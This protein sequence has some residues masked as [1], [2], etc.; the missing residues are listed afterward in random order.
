MTLSSLGQTERRANSCMVRMALCPM[1]R[2]HLRPGA[3]GRR[4][5]SQPPD[6]SPQGRGG[7]ARVQST[8]RLVYTSH[9]SGQLFSQHP[10]VTPRNMPN[11]N[12]WYLTPD[13]LQEPLNKAVNEEVSSL[14]PSDSH[15]PHILTSGPPFL[16]TSFL[17]HGWTQPAPGLLS[18]SLLAVLLL[19]RHLHSEAWL[20]PHTWVQ[21]QEPPASWL[22]EPAGML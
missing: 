21:N 13:I 14:N 9:V 15:P 17:L 20:C 2:R 4:S 3:H 22:Q 7:S 10:L 18:S 16:Q 6:L 19:P 8:A 11:Q 5:Y 1:G 12:C